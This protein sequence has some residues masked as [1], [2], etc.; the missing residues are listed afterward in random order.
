[1]K[2]HLWNAELSFAE[3]DTVTRTDVVLHADGRTYRA[4]GRAKRNP[5]D[6]DRPHIGYEIA[7]AR[8]LEHLALQLRGIAE[9]D[10]EE[11]EG[12]EVHVHL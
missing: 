7:A 11:F 9:H 3:G 8:A 6:P 12:R 4:W 10:I 2:A 1:M 5:M